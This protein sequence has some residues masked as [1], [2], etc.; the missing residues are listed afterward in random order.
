MFAPLAALAALL[1][2]IGVVVFVPVVLV[3]VAVPDEFVV[4]VELVSVP[5]VPLVPV[6]P[7]WDGVVLLVVLAV[8]VLLSVAP[9]VVSLR[10][11]QALN[12]KAAA[13]AMAPSCASFS[14]FMA[15]SL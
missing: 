6:A 11:W 5:V 1:E 14:V 8:V 3:P 12:D 13:S 15:Q 9:V 2:S 10:R 4:P 7:L